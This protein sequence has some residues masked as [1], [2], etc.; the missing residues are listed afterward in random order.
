MLTLLLLPILQT[1]QN[2]DG[3]AIQAK[4]DELIKANEKARDDLIGLEK[5][6]EEE[7]EE[8]RPEFNPRL[9][10]P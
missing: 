6:A 7:V 9:I 1:S 5:R 3:A 10:Q 4:L 2:H 8:L